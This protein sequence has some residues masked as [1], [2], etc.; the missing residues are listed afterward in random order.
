MSKTL[1][2]LEWHNEKRKIK[3]LIPY[4][5]NPRRLTKEQY[6][7]LKKSLTKF[8]LAEVPAVDT[9]GKIVAGHQRVATLI[10]M[11]RGEETIDVRVPNRK[12]TE[13]EFK[14]Y[15]L[16][17]N[18]N[19]GEWNYDELSGFE[20]DLLRD[21]GFDDKE[22]K[23]FLPESGKGQ[24]DGFDV[25]TAYDKIAKNPKVK[26]GDLFQL[27]SHRLLCGDCTI[28]ENVD[29]L[30][31]GEKADMVFTD[32]PY[33][34][35]YADKNKFLN[36]I[37]RG[38]RMQ[39]KISGD[40]KTVK[41]LQEDIIYPAFCRIK[42]ALNTKSSYYITAPQGGDLLMMMMM[43]MKAGL[44]L[45]HMLIWVKNNHVLG[46][47]D[48]NYKHEPILYGWVDRHNFYGNGQFQFSTWEINKPNKSDLHP[49]MKPIA[50]VVN[51]LQN[52]SKTQDNILDLF[53]GSGT[54]L[55]ACEQTGRKCYGMEI[56]PVYVEIIIDRWEKL[57]GKEA[58]KI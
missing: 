3:D 26:L 8:N 40:H 18:K 29:K 15:N 13:A 39:N 51:A 47:T 24:E 36:T 58:K 22:L 48:Y 7:Q 34:V 52:S 16:R 49:T 6:N 53:L 50:L 25:E 2:K 37:A 19:T 23:E 42:E 9:D 54:T 55:I 4:E 44:T 10:T 43:M 27:G 14:E 31:G 38:N 45:R 35:S 41:N 5:H 30:M 32:P 1:K 11:G 46:R 20:E 33:G 57:T 12:L 56:D 28:K 21:V 17:S